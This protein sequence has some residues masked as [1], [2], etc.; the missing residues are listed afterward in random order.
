MSALRIKKRRL[1]EK[2]MPKEKP[3]PAV[4]TIGHS[5]HTLEEFIRLLR[6]HGA[7]CAVDVRTVPCSRPN[8]QFKK[9]SLPRSL[10]KSGLGDMFP[11]RDSAAC[12]MR[13]AIRPTWASEM[14][15]FE[16]MRITCKRPSLRR[17]SKN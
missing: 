8:S 15:P 2:S 3:S 11:R 12:V 7:T 9:A 13:S 16:V 6:A 17:A 5:R 1:R 10:K 14:P 4:M